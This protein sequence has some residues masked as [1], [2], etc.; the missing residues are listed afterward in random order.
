[1]EFRFRHKIWESFYLAVYVTFRTLLRVKLLWI[2]AGCVLG[3]TI[4]TE[5]LAADLMGGSVVSGIMW[6]IIPIIVSGMVF[7]LFVS[8]ITFLVSW[9]KENRYEC[10]LNVKNGVCYVKTQI[11]PK[12]TEFFCKSIRTVKKSGPLLMLEMPI[13]EF[14]SSYLAIPVRVFASSKEQEAFLEYFRGQQVEKPESFKEELS[15]KSA[16]R[17]QIEYEMDR[18]FLLWASAQDEAIG[19]TRIFGLTRRYC[20]PFFVLLPIILLAC[21]MNLQLDLD[22]I[23]MGWQLLLVIGLPLAVFF[24][25]K[26]SPVK[27]KDVRR[28]MALGMIRTDVEG[29]WNLLFGDQGIQYTSPS[30]GGH[31]TWGEVNYLVESDDLF[32][33]YTAQGNSRLFF[34]KTLLGGVEQVQEFAAFCQKHGMEHKRITPKVKWKGVQD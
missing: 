16:G 23:G 12:P 13:T 34:R 29:S 17:W 21:L 32:F 10:F 6:G 8:L 9:L 3:M 27:E 19:R 31:F 11:Q 33:F 22:G 25:I 18:D 26:I 20:A 4:L 7:L 30:S 15:R 24:Y 1:M 2:L 28:R 5:V 14:G